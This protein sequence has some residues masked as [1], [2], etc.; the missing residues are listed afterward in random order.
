M[1][2]SKDALTVGVAMQVKRAEWFQIYLGGR[3]SDASILKYEGIRG[4]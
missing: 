3:V 4:I 1:Q 2:K